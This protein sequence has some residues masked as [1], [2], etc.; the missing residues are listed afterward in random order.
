MSNYIY[1]E[2]RSK[3]N[4]ETGESIKGRNAEREGIYNERDG[5]D[6]KFEN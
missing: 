5:R 2:Q 6:E 1:V 4:T 3:L